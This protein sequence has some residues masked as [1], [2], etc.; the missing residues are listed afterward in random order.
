MAAAFAV[1]V[2]VWS[3]E[4]SPELPPV[5]EAALALFAVWSASASASV[6]LIDVGV[7]VGLLG[8]AVTAAVAGRCRLA[9][10]SGAGLCYIGG[11]VAATR[12][13]C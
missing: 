4:L 13:P 1:L 7:L 8:L 3:A 11:I 2:A 6:V 9:L 10:W 12:P 5:V